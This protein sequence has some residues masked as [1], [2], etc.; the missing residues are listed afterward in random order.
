MFRKIF[1]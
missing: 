1:K